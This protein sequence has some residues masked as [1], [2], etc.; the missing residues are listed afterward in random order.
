[1]VGM[2]GPSGCGKSAVARRA[3]ARL[4]GKVISMEVYAS[5]NRRMSFE[6]RCRQNYDEPDAIDIE[7]LES[8]IRSFAAGHAI[9][10]PIYDFAQHLRTKR[11][12]H[13]EVATLLIVEGILALHFPSLRP[14]FDL[15]IYLDAPDEICFHRRRVR[16]ITERQRST[17]FILW[18]YQNTVLP[19]ATRYLIPS[20]KYAQV[21]IDTSPGLDAVEKSLCDTI[22]QRRTAAAGR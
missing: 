6:D 7:L 8:H 2:C 15:S 21:V 10:L 4:N 3:A 12:E 11:T 14:Y 22:L 17:E 18:Q 1:M 19:A 9:D 20:R 5:D 13:V 16:D